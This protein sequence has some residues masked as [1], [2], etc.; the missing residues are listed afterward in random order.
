VNRKRTRSSGFL[1]SRLPEPTIST[2]SQAS[3]T[4]RAQISVGSNALLIH[5]RYGLGATRSAGRSC[6]YRSSARVPRPISCGLRRLL[7]MALDGYVSFR[8]AVRQVLFRTRCSPGRSTHSF[9]SIIPV[10]GPVPLGRRLCDALEL[11]PTRGLRV[12]IICGLIGRRVHKVPRVAARSAG[13]P[14]T[15]GARAAGG[16][17]ERASRQG[18]F[19]TVRSRSAAWPRR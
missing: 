3:D 19:E 6:V 2:K 1:R 11:F 16:Q 5:G 12:P 7:R 9:E 4:S 10:G 8:S 17:T 18:R 14:E 15:V 13:F